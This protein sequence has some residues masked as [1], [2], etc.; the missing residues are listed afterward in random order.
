MNRDLRAR[1]KQRAK[2]VDHSDTDFEEGIFYKAKLIGYKDIKRPKDRVGI[3]AAMREIRFEHKNKNVKKQQVTIGISVDG[4]RVTLAKKANRTNYRPTPQQTT[5]LT[6]QKNSNASNN[7]KSPLSQ[8][9]IV[10]MHDEIN[11]IFYVSHDSQ[12]LQVWS[13]I[14]Q[15]TATQEFKC[16]VFKSFKK[17]DAVRVV[18]TI[19]QSFDVCHRI[20]ERNKKLTDDA[21]EAERLAADE[22]VNEK[23]GGKEPVRRPESLPEVDDIPL[24]ELGKELDDLSPVS[25]APVAVGIRHSLQSAGAESGFSKVMCPAGS[26]EKAASV[27]QTYLEKIGEME[28]HQIR[29]ERAYMQRNI[30]SERAATA[31]ANQKLS[32]SLTQNKSLVTH[33]KHLT[34]YISALECLVQTH[35]TDS[36]ELL[37]TLRQDHEAT[38]LLDAPA[39]LPSKTTVN[40]LVLDESHSNLQKYE[41]QLMETVEESTKVATDASHSTVKQAASVSSS[42]TYSSRPKVE[43]LSSNSVIRP[44]EQAPEP[45]APIPDVIEPIAVDPKLS[46][47]NPFL[48]DGIVHEPRL[49]AG[50]SGICIQTSSKYHAFRDIE[51]HDVANFSPQVSTQQQSLF[52][53]SDLPLMKKFLFSESSGS[54]ST[55]QPPLPS[56]GNVLSN[57]LLQ[58][59]TATAQVHS[60]IVNSR[61]QVTGTSLNDSMDT[62]VPVSGAIPRPVGSGKELSF[63]DA[64]KII[65]ELDKNLQMLNEFDSGNP[66]ES[67]S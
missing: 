22:R 52:G 30:D 59:Q 42:N 20:T 23:A 48:A 13:Y 2:N 29:I 40:Q 58:E 67:S 55:N 61:F 6:K 47:T 11:R 5:A 27:L 35:V 3:V 54:S 60:G 8:T 44:I 46:A 62:K 45:V 36:F 63:P 18:H 43:S 19:G 25:T 31:A 14:A 17:S 34:S 53:K 37:E 64:A 1:Q 39:A 28:T 26:S 7:A 4:L 16:C 15:D 32:E 10:L 50:Q 65:A 56:S 51:P 9:E 38:E 21:L 41:A 24:K 66:F 12:D 57:G 33:L 49:P